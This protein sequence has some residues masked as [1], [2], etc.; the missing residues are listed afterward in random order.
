M[1][2]FPLTENDLN[3]GWSKLNSEAGWSLAKL[4]LWQWSVNR[5]EKKSKERDPLRQAWSF[6][7][8]LSVCSGEKYWAWK[9]SVSAASG[10]SLMTGKVGLPLCEVGVGLSAAL[11]IPPCPVS[12]AHAA[13]AGGLQL[14]Q[15]N[16]QC[17]DRAELCLRPG[18]QCA[19]TAGGTSCCWCHRADWSYQCG[20]YSSGG[21][22]AL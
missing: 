11:E 13:A 20:N 5:L 9:S 19:G 16:C 15:Q 14:Q 17:A 6:E 2:L 21:A 12:I 3:W 10:F 4:K 7:L 22:A 18:D 1:V 8:H